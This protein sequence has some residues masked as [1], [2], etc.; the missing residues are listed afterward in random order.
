MKLFGIINFRFKL[1]L[2]FLTFIASAWLI[3][4]SSDED[5]AAQQ[6]DNFF[7]VDGTKY[8]PASTQVVNSGTGFFVQ[9]E[10]ENYK[11]YF[12]LSD[13]V[14]GDYPIGTAT[15]NVPKPTDISGMAYW[16]DH[17][18]DIFYSDAGSVS[19]SIESNHVSTSFYA[20]GKNS[21]GRTSIIN[22]GEI[23]GIE[24]S[25][26]S[27]GHCLLSTSK[28]NY[29][30]GSVQNITTNTYG[31][32]GNGRIV[33]RL[34][35]LSQQSAP[36]VYYYFWQDDKIVRVLGHRWY[37]AATIATWNYEDNK[38]VNVATDSYDN[39]VLNNEADI[40]F[41]YTADKITKVS[42]SSWWV[43]QPRLFFTYDG[44]N[45]S[46]VTYDPNSPLISTTYSLYDNHSNPYLLLAQ[47]MNTKVNPEQLVWSSAT[48]PQAL[49]ANNFGKLEDTSDQGNS[50]ASVTYPAYIPEGYPIEFTLS[51]SSDVTGIFSFT[52]FGCGD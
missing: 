3:S 28:V 7:V 46:T 15:P 41:E 19:V 43:S 11:I 52:Y 16:V 45:V 50:S 9:V 36:N 6:D 22:G 13:S 44:S 8:T 24:I 48:F 42:Y 35:K 21:D 40:T 17:S 31:Y 2:V 38:L 32:D 30:G 12:L 1:R 47:A 49:S 14:A 33:K 5:P 37:N 20:S 34:E 27:A 39:G 10:D 29:P 26:P 23:D 18:G 4:C 51:Y 25:V